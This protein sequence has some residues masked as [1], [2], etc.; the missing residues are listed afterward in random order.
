MRLPVPHPGCRPPGTEANPYWS[1][2]RCPATSRSR[3]PRMTWSIQSIRAL[4]SPVGCWMP[5]PTETEG[6]MEDPNAAAREFAA[7]FWEDVLELEPM[8]GT[9]VGEERFDD[10][11]ADPGP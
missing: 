4:C 1:S 11:L 3:T 5:R 7:T 8:I 6:P 2:I 10:K 9:M